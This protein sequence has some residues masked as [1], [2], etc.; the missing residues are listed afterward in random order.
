MR[1]LPAL[2]ESHHTTYL[3]GNSEA[4]VQCLR[5]KEAVDILLQSVL[6]LLL[7]DDVVPIR[8]LNLNPKVVILVPIAL[9]V[10]KYLLVKLTVPR[11][12]CQYERSR[13]IIGAFMDEEALN[14]LP[15]RDWK[16]R[17]Q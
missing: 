6:E 17:R 11:S 10:Y 3:P 7:Q 16:L 5:V 14:N 4:L 8:L 15:V 13:V 9:V 12:S 2:I 1:Q